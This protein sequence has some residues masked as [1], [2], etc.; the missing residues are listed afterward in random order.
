MLTQSFLFRYVLYWNCMDRWQHYS[1]YDYLLFFLFLLRT[2]SALRFI[3]A[4]E[5]SI[6]LKSFLTFENIFRANVF[7]IL[8]HSLSYLTDSDRRGLGIFNV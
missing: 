2:L 3:I 7:D 8:S 6:F 1:I 4:S 5:C